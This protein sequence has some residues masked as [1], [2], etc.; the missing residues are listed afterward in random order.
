MLLL[1][2]YGK[3]LEE[4]PLR[5]KS[6]TSFITFGLGDLIC[7]K[8]E[9]R[10][11]SNK[12]WDKTRTIR[13]GSYG[14]FITPYLHLQFSKI[15]PYLFPGKSLIS[16]IKA[17]IFNQAVG[18]VITTSTFFIFTDTLSGK[19]FLEIKQ[20]LNL[21]LLPTLKANWCVWPFLMFI[22]FSFIPIPWM[23]LYSNI[24]GMFWGVYLS[25]VQNVKKD[26]HYSF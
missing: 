23:P 8:I 17:V 18:A 24:C 15:M 9:N 26:F 11:G 21:K 16:I 25:Y 5:T 10:Y 2:K 1:K 22:N 4:K 7:Q 20:N 13:Q 14:I 3:L 6:F 19:C 12:I